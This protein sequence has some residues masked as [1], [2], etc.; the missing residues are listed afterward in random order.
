MRAG[1]SVLDTMYSLSKYR[2]LETPV[3]EV[4]DVT[5]GDY[6]DKLDQNAGLWRPPA[7]NPAT[8]GATL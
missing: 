2:I 4:Y 8:L 5:Q 6:F 3:P 1:M 7:D